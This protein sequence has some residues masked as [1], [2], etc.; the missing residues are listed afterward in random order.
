MGITVAWDNEADKRTIH[1]DLAGY[2]TWE[3]FTE[4]L[5]TGIELGAGCASPVDLIVNLQPDCR[6]NIIS[7]E[8]L[9]NVADSY[10]TD[11]RQVAIISNDLFIRKIIDVFC[12]DFPVYRARVGMVLTLEAAREYIARS[13]Q[14]PGA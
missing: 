13:R 2:W 3:E 7:S 9:K 10:E 4:A 8:Q 11:V 1:I 12:K 6:A 5:N 14:T